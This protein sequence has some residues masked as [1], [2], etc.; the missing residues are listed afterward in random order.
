MSLVSSMNIAQQALSVSQAAI[1]TVSNNIANV[2]TDGYSKLRVNQASVANYTPTAGNA[3]MLA[4]SCSGVTITSVTRYSDQYLQNYY[5]QE[6][7]AYSYLNKYAS[8]A[9]NIEDLVNEL[10]DTGLSNALKNF[11]TAA[12]VLNDSPADITT[13]QNYVDA[14]NSVCS[15]FNTMAVNLNNT[16][17]S[18]TGNG[19]L[20]GSLGASEISNEI[21][22]VNS[23]L[24]QLAEVNIGIAKTYDG[25]TAS[26]SLLDQRDLL[27]S[28]L[29][30]LIPIS[31]EESKNGSVKIALDGKY[32]VENTEVR[33]YLSAAA[34]GDADNPVAINIV[35]KDNPPKVLFADLNDEIDSGS[36]GAILDVCGSNSNDFT[37]KGILDRLNTMASEFAAILNGIQVGDPQ[38]NGT[39]AMAMDKNTKQLIESDYLM[40]LSG[41]PSDIT[42]TTATAAT[43]AGD[44]AGTQI[45]TAGGITTIVTTVLNSNN[46]TT[47]T[48][49]SQ[50][51]ITAANMRV[52]S[53]IVNDPYLVATARVDDSTAVGV[54][55]EIGN[56]ANMA[57]VIDSRINSSYYSN[58]GGTTIEKYL[59]NTVSA[60]G[61]DVENINARFESQTLVLNQV[62]NKLQS[63]TGVNMDE[64][65][66][67]LIKYQRA[68]QAAAR[69]F[70]VCKELLEELVKLGS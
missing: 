30:E 32:L 68:Y 28:K 6:N 22:D 24:N 15:V 49:M 50:P 8:I 33:G 14:A 37:I 17:E 2:G 11:Y 52:N 67:E 57:L 31:V 70:G 39:V 42:T 62:Q 45:T 13:R 66:T 10:N 29:S 40:F 64:E 7:S 9:S 36:F 34:T 20:D 54:G 5:R 43:Q 56:N 53:A 38:G 61:S 58:L 26:P 60:M 25:D 47:V 51:A 46:T 4:E 44:T 27:I 18:L 48:T 69:I 12:G 23:L 55:N 3:A 21:E 16:K 63:A 65:L 1:T 35:N 19:S 41:S 59:A